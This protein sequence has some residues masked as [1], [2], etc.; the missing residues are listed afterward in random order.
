MTEMKGKRSNLRRIAFRELKSPPSHFFSK[1]ITPLWPSLICRKN[2]P[3]FFVKHF[4]SKIIKLYVQALLKNVVFSINKS[5]TL[6]HEVN[7]YFKKKMWQNFFRRSL[8]VKIKEIAS[9]YLV[10]MGTY[11]SGKVGRKAKIRSWDK[12][13]LSFLTS[14][15]INELKYFLL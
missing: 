2:L 12:C 14:W 4:R 5:L 8:L 9:L 11:C 13:N 7:I 1:K 10:L 6:L 15:I 3:H